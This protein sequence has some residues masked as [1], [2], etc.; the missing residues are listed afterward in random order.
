MSQ[1]NSRSNLR[2][3]ALDTWFFRES[4]PMEA[5]GGAELVSV[6][7]PPVRTLLGAVRTAIGDAN[8]V[9]WHQFKDNA[10]LQAQIGYGSDDFGALSVVGPWLS[11]AEQRLF[12]IPCFVVRQQSTELARMRIGK[13]I[14]SHLSVMPV[15]LA[16]TAGPGRSKPLEQCWCT[17]ENFEQLLNGKLLDPAAIYRNAQLYQQEPRLGIARDVTRRITDEGKLY[18]TKHLRP[19]ADLVIE[20]ELTH[21][22]QTELRDSLLRLGGEGRLAHV[23]VSAVADNSSLNEVLKPPVV[24]SDTCGLILILLTAAR[25]ESQGNSDWL[26]KELQPAVQDG[27]QVW[28]GTINGV[29]LTLHAA[30]LGKAQREGGWDMAARKPRAVQSL[31]PAG[32]AY[33]VTVNGNISHAIEKLHGATIGEDQVLGRGL[34]A[35]GLWQTGEFDI[36]HEEK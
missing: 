20:I 2:F 23:R 24:T 33:Y 27:A 22:G 19:V 35:C 34:L 3:S 10:A 21:N 36:D 13:P 8:G 14:Q 5:L 6:F 17:R 28:Q 26:P 25:F 1:A 11:L 29:E 18:Q 31:I 30:V 16:E 4:R 7:P 32:S 12:P 15:R 9:D